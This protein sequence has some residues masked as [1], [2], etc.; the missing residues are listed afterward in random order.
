MFCSKC[1]KQISDG[2]T[3]CP[4]CG[5]QLNAPGASNAPN[6]SSYNAA[7]QTREPRLNTMCLVGFV[8]SCIS[9]LLNFFGLV[10]IAGVI[11]STIGMTGCNRNGE[12]G[13]GLAITGIIIGI[14]SI[15]YALFAMGVFG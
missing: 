5:A 15:F 9:L 12:K 1:G 3:F 10:G 13:K 7:Q 2:S 6:A 11:V 14:F 4:V 8:I